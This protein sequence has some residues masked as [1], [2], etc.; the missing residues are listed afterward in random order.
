LQ[1]PEEKY[2]RYFK[3]PRPTAASKNEVGKFDMLA[4]EK[5]IVVPN[6]ALDGN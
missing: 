3:R 6:G 5:R 2:E 4:N 1:L